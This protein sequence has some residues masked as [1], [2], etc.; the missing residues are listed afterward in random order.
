MTNV[1]PTTKASTAATATPRG[2]VAPPWGRVRRIVTNTYRLLLALSALALAWHAWQWQR[3]REL[4][5]LTRTVHAA[6]VPDTAASAAARPD[7]DMRLLVVQATRLRTQ[8]RHDDAVRILQSLAARSDLD[9]DT[10]QV[11]RF[12]LGNELLALALQ[13]NRKDD[14]DRAMTLVELAKQRYREVLR[15]QPQH[16]DARHNLDIALRLVPET[17]PPPPP[18]KP[19]N[20]QRIQVDLRGIRGVDLP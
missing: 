18:E 6:P 14:E 8:G 20:V 12:N 19:T 11:V 9:R 16:W 7:A 17:E 1:T 3:A 4:R 10:A 15:V 2:P 13:H 5:S